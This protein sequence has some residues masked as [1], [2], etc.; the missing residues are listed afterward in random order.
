MS[1]EDILQNVKDMTREELIHLVVRLSQLN[2]S[3]REEIKMLIER[4]TE[5]EA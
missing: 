1:K 4:L 2:E 3:L 5:T